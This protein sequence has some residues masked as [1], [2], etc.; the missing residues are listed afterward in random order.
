MGQPDRKA[1]GA[2]L[3]GDL[4]LLHDDVI[5][6]FSTVIKAAVGDAGNLLTVERSRTHGH[7][8]VVPGTYHRLGFEHLLH[9]DDSREP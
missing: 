1:H 2:P 6:N 9:R 7:V 4:S 8:M 5:K 3:H